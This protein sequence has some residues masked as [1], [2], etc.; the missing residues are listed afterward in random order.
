MMMHWMEVQL[1]LVYKHKSLQKEE[2]SVTENF[3]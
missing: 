1:F 2:I 3:Q